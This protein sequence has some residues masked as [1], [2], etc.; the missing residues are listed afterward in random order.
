V[1]GIDGGRRAETLSF[2]EFARL[3]DALGRAPAG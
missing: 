1:A 3:A 2:E